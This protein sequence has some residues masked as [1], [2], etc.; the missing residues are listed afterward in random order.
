MHAPLNDIRIASRAMEQ[1]DRATHPLVPEHWSSASG[2]H[3]EIEPTVG[4]CRGAAEVVDE[5]GGVDF[6]EK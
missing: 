4:L 2:G 3:R 6:C 1:R 5:L